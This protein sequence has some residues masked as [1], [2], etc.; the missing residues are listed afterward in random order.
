MGLATYH[1]VFLVIVMSPAIVFGGAPVEPAGTEPDREELF[2]ESDL[3]PDRVLLQFDVRDD[4]SAHARVEYR[5]ALPESNRTD[6][7]D[8]LQRD[9]ATNETRYLTRFE[10]RVTDSVLTGAETTNRSMNATNVSVATETAQLP[11]PYGAVVYTFT[12]EEFAV[13]RGEEILVG[14]A[15][16]GLYLDEESELQLSWSDEYEA[17]TVSSTVDER[18]ENAAVWSGPLWFDH[19]GPEIVLAPSGGSVDRLPSVLL[20]LS[21]LFALSGVAFWWLGSR[22]AD[23][24]EPPTPA[25]SVSTTVTAHDLDREEPVDAGSTRDPPELLSNEERVLWVLDQHGGRVKQQVVVETLEWS[26][27]KASRVVS[28]LRERGEIEGFR[29]GNENVLAIP[30][31]EEEEP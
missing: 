20:G 10:R 5:F 26:D 31:R 25:D 28:N 19:T 24:D 18:R 15:L 29:L 4:G 17:E 23:G 1:S 6:A 2:Q 27:A 22:S 9:I 3:D 14:D 30:S 12:W 13:V 16:A 8:E 11:Q 21:L 7:F